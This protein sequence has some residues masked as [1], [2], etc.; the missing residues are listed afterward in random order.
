MKT[1]ICDI[2]GTLT[3]LWPV[4]AMVLKE[5]LGDEKLPEIQKLRNKG[6]R[7]TLKIYR[8]ISREKISK[9]DFTQKYNRKFLEMEKKNQLPQL[10]K[11]PLVSLIMKNSSLNFV[12]ATG[13]QRNE[14]LYALKSLGIIQYFDLKYSVDKTSCRFGKKTGIPFKKILKKY[15]DCL[16][17]TDS[18]SD[19]DGARFVGISFTLIK[20]GN[21]SG[22]VA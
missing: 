17:L 6:I 7:E 4:E 10:K 12:Y 5:L 8:K 13:G 16:L 11:F 1:L 15:S 18:Q 14:A 21:F 20:N 22:S 9:R 2:D 19:C 3:D